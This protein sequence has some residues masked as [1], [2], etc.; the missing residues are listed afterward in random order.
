[1]ADRTTP[2]NCTSGCQCV[3]VPTWK[4]YDPSRDQEMLDTATWQNNMVDWYT[5]LIQVYPSVVGKLI[6]NLINVSL[7]ARL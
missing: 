2:L 7:Q 1:M 6:V 3:Q 5:K 4:P